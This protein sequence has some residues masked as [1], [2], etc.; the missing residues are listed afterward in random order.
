MSYL[1][2]SLKDTEIVKLQIYNSIGMLVEILVNEEKHAGTYQV[3]LSGLKL[4]TGI[5]YSK[6]KTKS[7]ISIV[8][9]MVV[10]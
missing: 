4:S 7:G 1:Q 9:K 6:L 5:Y 10:K 8:K 2:Y 3:S